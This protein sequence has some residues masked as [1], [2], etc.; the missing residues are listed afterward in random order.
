MDPAL[1]E[2]L[3]FGRRDGSEVVEAVIRLRRPG[4]LV[5]GGH[6]HLS[7]RHG[8]HVSVAD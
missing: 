4:M 7:V 2:L 3:R 5:P 6:H 1:R 8:S